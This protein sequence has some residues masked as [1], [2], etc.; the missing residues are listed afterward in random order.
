[1]N[2]GP[3]LERDS[4]NCISIAIGCQ[5]VRFMNNR[6]C[7]DVSAL[8]NNT[9]GSITMD[10]KERLELNYSADDFVKSSDGKIWLTLDDKNIVRTSHGLQ[11]NIDNDSI[12]YDSNENKLISSID[13]YLALFGQITGDIYLHSNNKMRLNI[14]NYVD[15]NVGSKVIMN[16]NNKIDVDIVDQTARSV[17]FDGNNKLTLRLGP[18]FYSDSSGYFY[19]A[20]NE[21]MHFIGVIT[22]NSI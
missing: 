20:I 10:N 7:L 12:R 14:N 4:Q 18:T 11:L 19:L 15:D 9:S 6:L 13:K 16:T 5:G 21:S 8:I 3:G 1:M 2:I 17:Y 22:I